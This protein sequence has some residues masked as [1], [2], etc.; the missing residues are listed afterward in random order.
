M[1]RRYKAK[2]QILK[3]SYYGSYC[4]DRNQILNNDRDLQVLFVGGPSK[5]R[6]IQAVGLVEIVVAYPMSIKRTVWKCVLG[7][8]SQNLD[9]DH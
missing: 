6:K 4:I 2:R 7:V 8:Y 5:L 9:A 1:N 3:P